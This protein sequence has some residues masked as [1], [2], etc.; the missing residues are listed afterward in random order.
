MKK[1][2][3]DMLL[4][5]VLIGIV[6]ALVFQCIMN[7]NTVDVLVTSQSPDARFILDDTFIGKQEVC[8][9]GLKKKQYSLEIETE[10]QGELIH[11]TLGSN[12]IEA[13]RYGIGTLKET[14]KGFT[15]Q[16]DVFTSVELT[17]CHK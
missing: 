5:G 3:I 8:L 6:I 14:E 13:E 9:S 7:K 2:F 1:T 12:K 11:M 16:T 17:N 4:F 10:Q 15:I